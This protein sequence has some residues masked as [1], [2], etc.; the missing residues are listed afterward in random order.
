M[1]L[2]NN[3]LEQLLKKVKLLLPD[4]DFI[5][6]TSFYWSPKNKTIHYNQALIDKQVGQWGLLHETAHA[7]LL[8][9]SYE[10]DA[11]LLA[12]EV[13]A[14]Q[15]AKELSN[16]FRIVLDDDHIQ[17]CLDTYREWLYAR[18]TCPS[19]MLNSLQTNNTTYLCLNCSTMW[20][21]T[22]SRFCRPYRMQEKHKEKPSE[23][24]QTVFK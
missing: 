1:T 14:W 5:E 12:L 17:D 22:T 21:V 20:S 6:S 18:S 2:R 13:D 24:P 15:R 10:S 11:G 3:T 8:H 4:V 7:I 23:T 16:E 19:C 9:K